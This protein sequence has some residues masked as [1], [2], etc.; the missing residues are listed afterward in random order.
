V[1]GIADYNAKMCPP[2][3]YCPLG[4]YSPIPCAAGTFRPS[5]SGAGAGP[6]TYSV[7]G[8]LQQT[9][10][11]CVPGYYCPTKATVVPELC[12]KG[13]FCL[14]GSIYDTKCPA[15]YYCPAGSNAP[16]PCP[17]GFYCT[18][19]SDVYAKC[20]F[21]TYCPPKSAYPINCPNGS[22]GSGNSN[23]FDEASGCIKCGRG[24][25]SE[26]D[27]TQCFD[28]TPGYVC[29]GATSSARPKNVTMHNGY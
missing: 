13:S 2:G 6:T 10:F 5:Q 29:L 3:Y 22:Y 7:T 1:V 24:L 18:G 23:N 17:K 11:S 15:G 20:P 9:C 21:G 27:P 25:Y 26:D 4:T 19:A 16:T 14:K 12:P 8:N 28:C